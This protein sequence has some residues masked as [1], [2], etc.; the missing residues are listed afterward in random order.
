MEKFRTEVST[1]TLA[2]ALVTTVDCSSTDV[3]VMIE[4]SLV[5]SSK[6]DEGDYTFKT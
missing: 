1:S 4:C 2:G 3:S 6:I 5:N